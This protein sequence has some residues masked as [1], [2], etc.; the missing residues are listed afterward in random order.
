[1]PKRSYRKRRKSSNSSSAEE[2]DVLSKVTDIKG[3]QKHRCK[4][5]GINALSLAVGRIVS[6]EEALTGNVLSKSFSKS[7]DTSQEKY[8]LQVG[9]VFS[10]ES[11]QKE[12][13]HLMNSYIKEELAKRRGL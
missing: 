2:E 3:T 4:R 9:S 7:T 1:M 6:Q 5:G 8:G 12:E 13:D 11:N 10:A